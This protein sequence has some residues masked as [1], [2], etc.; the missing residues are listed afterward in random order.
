MWG[1][2]L[3]QLAI[4]VAMLVQRHLRMLLLLLCRCC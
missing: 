4:A 2:H 1:G 3:K